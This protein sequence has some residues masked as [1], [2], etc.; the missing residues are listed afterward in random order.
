MTEV[1]SVGDVRTFHEIS[2]CFS[3]AVVRVEGSTLQSLIQ[4]R[5]P[6]VEPS[7]RRTCDHGTRGSF[8]S[9]ARS[10][11]EHKPPPSRRPNPGALPSGLAGYIVRPLRLA[12]SFPSS[13]CLRFSLV[14]HGRAALP[15]T[16]LDLALKGRVYGGECARRRSSGRRRGAAERCHSQVLR[17]Y[18]AA[19][20]LSAPRRTASGY[21]V[22]GADM[23]DLLAFVR[24]AQRLGLSL[25]VGS[26]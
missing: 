1:A 20:I 19:G 2:G 10:A 23:L 3:W 11:R 16:A 13:P 25:E 4:A 14:H 7:E 6:I 17:L 26:P 24:Q 18:E 12:A 5:V 8:R 21:R 15:A 9:R 22:H